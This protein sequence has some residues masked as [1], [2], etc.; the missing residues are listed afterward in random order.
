MAFSREDI[1]AI[2]SGCCQQL[3]SSQPMLFQ[4][5]HDVNERTVSGELCTLMASHFPEYHVN[6]EY[7][8][9]TDES[10]TQIPK[11]IGR[12][13]N[14][15]NPSRVFP[16]II[17]HRQEDRL[18][19]LLVAELKMAWKNQDREEDLQKLE[20]YLEELN[21]EYGLYLELGEEGIVEMMWYPNEI[22]R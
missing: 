17:V 10:G 11:R 15:S 16:D 21:Y 7:N 13:P 18:H 20:A 5:Q 1:E 2:V 6:A 3:I 22:A 12:N 4:Q 14:D 9:M 8:R 19:N